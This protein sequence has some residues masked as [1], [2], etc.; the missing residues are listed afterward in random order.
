MAK[1]Y[2]RY[3]AMNA[4]KS[5]QALQVTHNYES[6]GKM[7]ML[8]TAEVDGRFGEG[9][10]TSRLG[11]SRAADCFND[12][13]DMFVAIE[14]FRQRAGDRLGAVLIDEA[15]FLSSEQVR[16]IH[17]AVHQLGVPVLCYGLRT[18]FR[19]QPFAGSTML[20]AL[21]ESLEEIKNVCSCGRKATMN[22]RCD[23]DGR[24][25]REGPQILIG[26]GNHR[27]SCACGFYTD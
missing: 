1:L 20:L 24:R 6:L 22:I 17:K 15:Q 12:S 5:T 10:I 11:V 13:T 14:Q 3:A 9:Q 16:Q 2:F 19:G 25:L 8:M 7:V 23:A 18:D 21:A 27:Q 4:G 26:D